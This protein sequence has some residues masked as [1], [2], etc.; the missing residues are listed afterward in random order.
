MSKSSSEAR[1]IK[2][3]ALTKSLPRVASL[4]QLKLTMPELRKRPK[5]QTTRMLKCWCEKCGY[6][7]RVSGK[8][9]VEAGA[10]YCGTKAHGRLNADGFEEE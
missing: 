6:T 7:T 9:L 1:S 5:K 2:R 8:W 4:K 10:P 3:L